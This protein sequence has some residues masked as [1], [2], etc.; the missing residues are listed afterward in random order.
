VGGKNQLDCALDMRARPRPTLLSSPPLAR[1]SRNGPG[2]RPAARVATLLVLLSSPL[3]CLDPGADPAAAADARHAE[4]EAEKAELETA[5]AAVEAK[6]DQLAAKL[7]TEAGCRKQVVNT[8]GFYGGPNGPQAEVTARIAAEAKAYLEQRVD[9][10]KRNEKLAIVLDIDETTL[11]NFEQLSG[12]GFC[13]VREEWDRWVADGQPKVIAGMKELYDYAHANE[14]AVVFITGRRE[15]QREATERALAD[16]GF[17]GWQELILRDEGETELSA[18]D[19][20]SAR[21]AKLE[22][23]GFTVVL[24]VGD[25]ASDLAGGHTERTMLMPNPFYHVD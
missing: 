2:L 17:E 25:Q 13:F 20:K 11:N 23:A 15:Y 8:L 4:L 3:A 7:D 19:Y 6:R 22:E 16:A 18:A 14:V 9:E 10:R 21:R 12:S 1:A 24:S 5:L